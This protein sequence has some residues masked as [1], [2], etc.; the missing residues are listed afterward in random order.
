MF[1]S[2]TPA[3]GKRPL[4][5]IASFKTKDDDSMLFLPQKKNTAEEVVTNFVARLLLHIARVKGNIITKC[6]WLLSRFLS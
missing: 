3:Y 1:A 5:N 4:A 2:F 6:R